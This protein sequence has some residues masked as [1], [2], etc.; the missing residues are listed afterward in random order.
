MC[1]V[2]LGLSWASGV[3]RLL[4]PRHALRAAA[5][6]HSGP[7]LRPPH[8]CT[9]LPFCPPSFQVD[10]AAKT[11]T[12]KGTVLREGDWLSLNGSSGEVLKGKQPVKPPELSGGCRE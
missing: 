6:P 11:A 9:L 2:S 5:P 1:R 7:P 8:T 10:Y 12:L 4:Q 3:A